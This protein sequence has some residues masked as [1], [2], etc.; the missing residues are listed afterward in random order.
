MKAIQLSTYITDQNPPEGAPGCVG[1]GLAQVWMLPHIATKLHSLI[2]IFIDFGDYIDIEFIDESGEVWKFPLEKIHVDDSGW[3]WCI[4]FGDK[5]I[6]VLE[7]LVT[8][9]DEE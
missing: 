5:F 6:P 4:R 2:P 3:D 8:I 9:E 7:I 1:F